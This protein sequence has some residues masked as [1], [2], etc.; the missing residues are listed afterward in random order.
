MLL[1]WIG[2]IQSHLCLYYSP[3]AIQYVLVT[4]PCCLFCPA[5]LLCALK[6][7]GLVYCPASI[8]RALENTATPLGTQD[9]FSSGHGIV[10]VGVVMGV[11]TNIPWDLLQ[12]DKAFDEIQQTASQRLAHVHFKV[13]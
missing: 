10:Q 7:E 8:K 12:V 2:F 1:V 3:A 9:A 6:D 13:C 11:V 5:L 4:G